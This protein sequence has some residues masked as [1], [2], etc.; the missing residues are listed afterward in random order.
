MGHNIR[1]I[2]D[3]IDHFDKL[4]MKGLM[5]FADFKKAFDSLDWNFMFKTL[6]FF[7]FGPSFKHWIKTLYNLPVG[8]VKN[9]GHISDEF[10]ISRGIR[11]GCPVSA[12][13]FILSIEMFAL[14]IRQEVDLKGYN[15]GYPEKPEKIVQYADDCILCGVRQSSELR[16]YQISQSEIPSGD[17]K[18]GTFH[19]ETR[20]FAQHLGSRKVTSPDGKM[21]EAIGNLV[22]FFFYLLVVSLDICG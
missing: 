21:P 16:K 11:Q 4:Q 20:G 1:L 9:N 22:L 7:N 19:S 13:I 10:K 12:L 2:E 17:V 15:F 5:F 8:K 3:V 18:C 14:K 6:D